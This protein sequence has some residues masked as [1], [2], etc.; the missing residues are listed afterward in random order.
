[1]KKPQTF[2][3]D[4]DAALNLQTESRPQGVYSS[5]HD[6]L[7]G[8]TASFCSTSGPGSYVSSTF[9]PEQALCLGADLC[10]KVTPTEGQDPRLAESSNAPVPSHTLMLLTP[11]A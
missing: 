8:P 11:A 1:M 4:A 2:L 7:L 9:S 5:G 3:E 6:T 10:A